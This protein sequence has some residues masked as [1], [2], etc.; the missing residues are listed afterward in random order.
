MNNIRNLK[1]VI[2]RLLFI[3]I[4][5]ALVACHKTNINDLEDYDAIE[6]Q[7]RTER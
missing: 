6:N 1:H 5:F 3:V 4:G 7:K 2:L